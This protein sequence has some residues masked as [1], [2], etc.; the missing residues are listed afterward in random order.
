VGTGGELELR[1]VNNKDAPEI[2]PNGKMLP[3]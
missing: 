3:L 1:I 2:K